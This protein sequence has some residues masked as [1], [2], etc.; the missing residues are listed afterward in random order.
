MVDGVQ[1]LDGMGSHGVV[2]A[3]TTKVMTS[4]LARSSG[5]GLPAPA[6]HLRSG[7]LPICTLV[8]VFQAPQVDARFRYPERRACNA[9]L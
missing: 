8:S 2:N 3:D 9:S 5:D 6:A 7:G 4:G 1:E